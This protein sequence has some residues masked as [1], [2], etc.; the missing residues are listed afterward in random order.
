MQSKGER[1]QTIG[2]LE[3]NQNVDEVYLL[4][5]CE[6]RTARNGSLYLQLT[7]SDRTGTI[8]GRMWSAS[9]AMVQALSGARFVRLKGR[10][11]TY[12][13]RLQVVAAGIR[14]VAGDEVSLDEFLPHIRQDVEE[15]WERLSQAARSISDANLSAL[16]MA[17]LADEKIARDF[18]R[19][20]A[21][22]SYH[23]PCLG[24]LL[25]HTVNVVELARFVCERY[26]GL[27][28][29]MFLTGA[30]LHDIGKLRELSY[31][32]PFEY[33]D[34]GRLLGHVVMGV[35]M[36][37]EKLH[38]LPD[39]PAHLHDA[40]CHLI[41]SHHGEYEWGAPKLPMT[42][43]AFALHHLDNLDAKVEASIRAIETARMPDS[44]W[45]EWNRMF[46]RMLYKGPSVPGA[47]GG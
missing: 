19:A 37:R 16:V 5:S 2:Q 18:K 23:Q 24:G 47:G 15:L 33:T 28:H 22:V 11:E 7:L 40:L 45:T 34:S 1:R 25:E 39:F 44:N 41:L 46:K 21:A 43:E 17:F 35:M 4:K 31:D 42:P 27:D 14:P 26:E 13:N 6:A 38:D 36:V 12:Q 8:D 20:P 10:T 32:G 30:I 3:P 9:E 29:D